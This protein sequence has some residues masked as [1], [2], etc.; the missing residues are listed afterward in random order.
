M[1]L[2]EFLHYISL[3][4][5]RHGNF[6]FVAGV[7]P[8]T[9]SD[10]RVGP[11]FENIIDVYADDGEDTV[12]TVEGQQQSKLIEET[13]GETVFLVT[14]LQFK[15][16]DIAKDAII[17]AQPVPV[18][19]GHIKGILIHCFGIGQRC[20]HVCLFAKRKI[21]I[22][23]LPTLSAIAHADKVGIGLDRTWVAFIV[24]QTI[25]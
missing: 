18:F 12:E 15:V 17:F 3:P 22:C 21:Q 19:Q 25:L 24:K 1:N 2:Q 14:V 16:A 9:T 20:R 5:Q 10:N 8:S 7:M 23:P 11:A 4:I 6:H 13:A